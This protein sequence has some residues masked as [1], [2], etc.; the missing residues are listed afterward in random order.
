MRASSLF[1][2]SPAAVAQARW[3]SQVSGRREEG[4]SGD[5]TGG[6]GIGNGVWAP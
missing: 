5:G 2:D 1:D 3:R 4:C 6:L